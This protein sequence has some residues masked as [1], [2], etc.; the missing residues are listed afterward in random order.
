[1]PTSGKIEIL[2]VNHPSKKSSGDKT[3][4][5]AMKSAI[6]MVLPA[7]APG[8]TIEELRDELL[9]KLPDA[10]FPGGATAGWWLKAVQLDLEAR[11]LIRRTNAKPLRLHK[12]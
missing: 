9:P 12:N 6:L 7:G 4:Y 3:K 1:M 5:T 8:I 2:N 11:G 10:A